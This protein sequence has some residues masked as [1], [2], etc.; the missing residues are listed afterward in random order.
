MTQAIDREQTILE[1]IKGLTEQQQQEV[2]NF[3]EFLQ[4]KAQKQDFQEE[5]KEPISAYEAAKEFIGCVESGIG[6]LSYNKKYL[7]GP[8]A[9]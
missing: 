9:G 6:D 5:E 3:I 2:L 8:S 4:F 7:Q 1:Q